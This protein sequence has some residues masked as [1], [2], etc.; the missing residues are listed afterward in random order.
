MEKVTSDNGNTSICYYSLGNFIHGQDRWER[1]LGAMA[2]I[3]VT[4]KWDVIEIKAAVEPNVCQQNK[5]FW[6]FKLTD[7]T[8][9]LAKKHRLYE[10]GLTVENLWNLWNQVYEVEE[11]EMSVHLGDREND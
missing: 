10:K 1:C 11:L 7:Y 2:M 8:E 9:E 6:P 4:K 3:T 5:S